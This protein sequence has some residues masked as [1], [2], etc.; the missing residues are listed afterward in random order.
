MQYYQNQWL[1]NK[2]SS[3]LLQGPHF[4][5]MDS[6]FKKQ[7]SFYCNI[8]IL[9]W[10]GLFQGSQGGYIFWIFLEGLSWNRGRPSRHFP[11]L[12]PFI[13]QKKGD[14]SW[15]HCFF[16]LVCIYCPLS[17]I[18]NKNSKY[19]NFPIRLIFNC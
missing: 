10:R 19:Q 11:C 12:L 3:Y 4:Y 8:L 9:P 17:R 5:A 7:R 6:V 16:S 14:V 1:H 15:W 13:G 18:F 2:G